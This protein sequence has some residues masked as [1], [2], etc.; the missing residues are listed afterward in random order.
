MFGFL[1]QCWLGQLTTVD[2]ASSSD[3]AER[4]NHP[5]RVA[6]ELAVSQTAPEH[7][8]TLSASARRFDCLAV[9]SPVA[10]VDFFDP[11][12]QLFGCV[13]TLF[14]QGPHAFNDQHEPV[15]PIVES[16]DFG[17]R[18]RGEGRSRRSQSGRAGRAPLTKHVTG[19]E[20]QGHAMILGNLRSGFGEIPSPDLLQ[21]E[22]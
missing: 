7:G 3:I 16:H 2:Q 10:A 14:E 9:E 19:Y 6:A 1:Q 22:P 5:G 8:A 12:N 13:A 15:D 11:G 4:I 20:V 18:G 17:G 21:V